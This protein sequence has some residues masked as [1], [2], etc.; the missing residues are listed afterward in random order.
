MNGD[1]SDYVERSFKD[2]Y[3]NHPDSERLEDAEPKVLLEMD[4][5]DVTYGLE[6]ENGYIELNRY[7]E[8]DVGSDYLFSVLAGIMEDIDLGEVKTEVLEE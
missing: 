8:T 6:T 2:F 5:G 1:L 4:S 3:S 7:T